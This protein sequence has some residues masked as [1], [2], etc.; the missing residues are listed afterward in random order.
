MDTAVVSYDIPAVVVTADL[1][2]FCGIQVVDYQIL[3]IHIPFPYPV[4]QK[5]PPV[6]AGTL[7][8]LF[9]EFFKELNVSQHRLQLPVLLF[10]NDL[11]DSVID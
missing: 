2:P 11:C 6:R 10:L 8:I 1:S 9:I 5:D 4:L 3:G 7:H